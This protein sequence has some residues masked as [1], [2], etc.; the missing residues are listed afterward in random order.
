MQRSILLR[1]LTAAAAACCLF[2]GAASATPLT[3]NGSFNADD[4]RFVYSFHLDTATTMLAR[5]S[6][7]AAGGF[8][9]VL[10]LFGAAGG[11]VQNAGSS[12]SCGSGSGT[13]DPATG[14]CWDAA[15]GA[16]LDAGDYSLVLTQDGNMAIGDTL[17]AGFQQDGWSHYTS[18]F[19]LGIPGGPLCMNV[20]ASQRSCGWALTVDGLAE[21]PAGEAP[22]PGSLALAGIALLGLCA[23]RRR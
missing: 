12:M 22:E 11:V 16:E 21:Q 19:A 7:W 6:S 2:A 9:P 3:F 8:A 17:A 14:F 20:D 5:T 13:A 1:R 4:D 10:T 15:L 23:T 18:E